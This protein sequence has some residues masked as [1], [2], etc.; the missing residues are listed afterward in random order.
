MRLFNLKNGIIV[1]ISEKNDMRQ[2]NG[3][4]GVTRAPM[5]RTALD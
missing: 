3:P 4:C 5:W 2:E 1:N